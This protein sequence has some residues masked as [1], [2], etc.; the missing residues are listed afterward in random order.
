MGSDEA[1]DR[2]SFLE[3]ATGCRFWLICRMCAH[4]CPLADADRRIRDELDLRY[5]QIL[6]RRALADTARRIIVRA[7][8]GAEPAVVVAGLA[9]GNT[10]EMRADA[11]H[12]KILRL[13]F[14]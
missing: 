3:P 5:R 6:R 13:V 1:H 4:V 14:R 8:T 11:H 9:K 2:Q 7:V 10:A 12:Q